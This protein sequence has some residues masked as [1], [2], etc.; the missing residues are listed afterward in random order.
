MRSYP[1][2]GDKDNNSI[3]LKLP[4]DNTTK[5]FETINYQKD[6]WDLIYGKD[7]VWQTT[8]SNQQEF[9]I[10]STSG[11]LQLHEN[12]WENI[13]SLCGPSTDK[14]ADF[15]IYEDALYFSDGLRIN[16]VKG[17]E[18]KLA[19]EIP[20]VINGTI[21][22]HFEVV[23]E[24]DIWIYFQNCNCSSS[25]YHFVN[26]EW[27]AVE[28]GD[29]Q[30]YA[31]DMIKDHNN[32]IWVSSIWPEKIYKI[33]SGGKKLFDPTQVW[34]NAGFYSI[35]IA[36]NTN[37]ELWA[38]MTN[39]QTGFVLSADT[40]MNYWKFNYPFSIDPSLMR[41]F[42]DSKGRYWV[43]GCKILD[44]GQVD[45][46][47]CLEYFYNNEWYSFSNMP[48][49]FVT[50]IDEDNDGNVYISTNLGLYEYMEK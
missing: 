40:E 9:W 43:N 11:I 14:I 4:P 39:E 38:V 37:N 3:I 24:G 42:F 34:N 17:T 41:S 16:K 20:K 44:D 49:S 6:K 1:D 45:Q 35:N 30:Y 26:G 25:L 5:K 18:C 50:D 31:T 15:K 32:D 2:K 48:F 10:Q 46:Y 19:Y 27:T 8:I 13:S 33:S 36:V 47:S 22:T 7:I 21:N 28:L 23:A 29:K 12:Q